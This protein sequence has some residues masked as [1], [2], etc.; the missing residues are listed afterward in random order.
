MAE[1]NPD[2]WVAVSTAA[3]VLALTH[4]V[5]AERIARLFMR[6][7]WTV[8]VR[9]AMVV[10]ASSVGGCVFAFLWALE[11]LRSH[12]TTA[13]SMSEGFLIF[14]FF[15][16]VGLTALIGSATAPPGPPPPKRR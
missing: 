2:F 9:A 3:P 5:L 16:L 7:G 4:T 8:R 12:S 1:G 14:A 10:N 13:E 11:G 6:D 15:A